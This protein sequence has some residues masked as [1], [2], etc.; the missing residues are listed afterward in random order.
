MFDLLF[1]SLPTQEDQS[2]RAEMKE[3]DQP[4]VGMFDEAAGV[5]QGEPGSLDLGGDGPIAATMTFQFGRI[6]IVRPACRCGDQRENLD[7]LS[8]RFQFG[9]ECRHFGE[10]D[11]QA[12]NHGVGLKDGKEA[13]SFRAAF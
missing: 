2:V 5:R 10:G 7:L 13:R 8:E 4:L 12:R 6:G 1:S 11:F 3:I 9:S